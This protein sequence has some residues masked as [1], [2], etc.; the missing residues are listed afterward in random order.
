MILLYNLLKGIDVSVTVYLDTK[1]CEFEQCN[2]RTTLPQRVGKTAREGL[3]C[4]FTSMRMAL[5]G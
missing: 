5:K 2:D 3:G 1:H 4:L